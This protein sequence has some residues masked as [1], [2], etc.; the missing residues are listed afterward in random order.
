MSLH[1]AALAGI[2]AGQDAV[3]GDL[4]RII[5]AAVVQ[6]VTH[7]G[8]HQGEGLQVSEEAPGQEGGVGEDEVDEVS[9]SEAVAPVVVGRRPVASPHQQD[10][11]GQA[12]PGDPPPADHPQLG[13]HE[14]HGA[15]RVPVRDGPGTEGELAE[16]LA[17][18]W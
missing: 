11:P 14:E 6:V 8:Y 3:A 12:V 2:E 13:E 10:E 5:G 4:V 9:D 7:R 1:H 17:E 18:C 16:V 15:H